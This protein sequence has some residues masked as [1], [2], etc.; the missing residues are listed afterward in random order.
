M[1][2]KRD[3]SKTRNIG[4][5]AHIDAGKT[6][7]TE[8]MLYYTG[9]LHKM[10]EV[11]DGNTF[12]DWME[13]ERERGITITSAVTTFY[14]NDNQ[15]NI[16]DTPG[17]VDFTA[18]VQRSLRVLDG[19]VGVFCA[20]KGV[21]PQSETVWHQADKFRVPRLVF[22]NKMD[23]IAADFENAI[24]T[25]HERLSHNAVP[26][27]LP[28][29]SS[30]TFLGVVDIV[31]LKAYYFDQSTLGFKYSSTTE[32]PVEL[33]EKVEIYRE[34][35]LETLSEFDEDLMNKYLEGEAVSEEEIKKVIRKATI[36]T[37]FVPVLCGS[38]L[39]NTG[40]QLLIDAVIDYLPSPADICPAEAID[41]KTG[42]TISVFNDETAPF[43]AL[44]YKVRVDKFVGKMI[45]VRV[46]SGTLK[47]G[48]VVYNQTNGKRQRVGRILQVFSNKTND[49]ETISAGDIA[50]IIGPK[51]IFT[52][53]TITS[54]NSN[55]LLS[56]ISFPD[57]VISQAVEAK[58]KP[59][60]EALEIA[61]QK[62]EEEDPTF[63]VM[64]DKETGQTLITGMGELHLEIIV[65]RLKREYN[66]VPNIGKPQVSYKE[67]ITK[68]TYAEGEFIRELNGKGHFAIVKIIMRPMDSKSYLSGEKRQFINSID[69]NLI[70]RIFWNAVED[71]CLNACSDGPLLSSPVEKI[72]IELVD[73]KA[74]EID[75]SETAFKIASSMAINKGLME[76][77][78]ILMEPIMKVNVIT[79]EDYMGDVISDINSKRGKIDSI[80]DKKND[81]KEIIAE[82][83]MGEL[84][85]YSTRLRSMSQGRAYYT[86][87]F[88][89]YENV[90][91]S[92]QASV[93]KR[94]RGY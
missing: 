82:I 22:I 92:I 48:E 47:K 5:I 18:E 31:S 6:T 34:H 52:G 65:D 61:L 8:R 70:P 69:T 27:Q 75:S 51:D 16:I 58:S 26:I 2:E 66:V 12:M 43:A 73:G 45:Y 63:R 76:A 56:K 72:V 37:Q 1:P 60:Q 78:P 94:V 32:I 87:E 93:L 77:E 42:E 11:H 30:D 89:K 86:M 17:H 64:K 91:A 50:A 13:Q 38:S 71:G 4:I 62:M 35:L 33:R 10:G 55:I 54:E 46:Y 81:N 14:W 29:G 20:V 88:L 41:I 44:A 85:G 39:K 84:F 28:I 90:P 24:D 79:P 83:P 36:A 21:E 80:H 25:I 15:I 9:F 23:R 7:T 68:E 74:H 40:I 19:A 67:T 53:D 57:S 59:D 49:I 3:I